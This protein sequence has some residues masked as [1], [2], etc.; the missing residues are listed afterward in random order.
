VPGDCPVFQKKGDGQE[1]E[2]RN[3]TQTSRKRIP[4]LAGKERFDRHIPILQADF[5]AFFNH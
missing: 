5:A 2:P 4:G 1:L 3:S